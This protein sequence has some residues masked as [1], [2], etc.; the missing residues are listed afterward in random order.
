MTVTSDNSTAV[1]LGCTAVGPLFSHITNNDMSGGITGN[2]Y[3]YGIL[4]GSNSW[5]I[6]DSNLPTPVPTLVQNNIGAVTGGTFRYQLWLDSGTPGGGN[7]VN[8]SGNAFTP[9]GGDGTWDG[10][11]TSGESLPQFNVDEN[12]PVMTNFGAGDMIS[13]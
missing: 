13:P 1:G 8:W 5:L 12:Q 6:G 7:Y 11:Y 10:N 3:A 9:A 2:W 4:L